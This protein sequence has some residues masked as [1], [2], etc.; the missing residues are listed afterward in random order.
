MTEDQ[1]PY[2]CPL[3]TRWRQSLTKM[4]TGCHGEVLANAARKWQAFEPGAK[5]CNY[6]HSVGVQRTEDRLQ[7]TRL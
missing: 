1:T 2:I 6:Q 3:L 7:T 5:R 4:L